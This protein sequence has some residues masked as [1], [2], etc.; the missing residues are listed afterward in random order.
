MTTE[1][2]KK[3]SV[4][5]DLNPLVDARWQEF[6]D[7]RDDSSIFHTVP[8][9]EAIRCTYGYRPIVFTSSPPREPLKDGFL[10]CE[11]STWLSGRRL[12]SVPFSDHTALLADDPA[13]L[14][15]VLSTLKQ[16]IKNK[17]YKYIEIRPTFQLNSALGLG[18]AEIFYWHKLDLKQTQESL[19]RSFHKDCVQ[20]KIRRAER[21]NLGYE[22]GKSQDLVQKFYGLQLLTRKRH[23]LPPQPLSW[24]HNLSHCLGHGI[25]IRVASMNDIPIASIITMTHK[26]S[27]TYKY[28]CSDSKYHKLGG[29]IFLLWR[30]IQD[31]QS[32]GLEEFDMGR[33]ALDNEGLISFK[34]HWGAER[35]ELVYWAYPPQLRPDVNRWG[36]KAARGLVSRLPSA[37]LPTMG[38]LLYRHMG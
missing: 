27:M 18:K 22:E 24:F 3:L 16:K 28:S 11:V 10:F 20:R 32:S 30:A 37:L 29:T 15:T 31:A 23:G 35:S 19:Y 12:V 9:L 14:G 26:K 38:R 36:V 5:Y 4:L 21:D 17:A 33:S 8:W 7:R 6:I 2:R 34:E 25:R 13:S 1:E